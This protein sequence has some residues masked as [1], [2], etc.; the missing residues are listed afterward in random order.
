MT[1]FVYNLYQFV[2]G[3]P[4]LAPQS[5]PIHLSM[6]IPDGMLKNW[7]QIW[8]RVMYYKRKCLTCSLLVCTTEQHCF[9]VE[10]AS[11][12]YMDVKKYIDV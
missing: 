4:L 5:D 7:G 9:F 11:I 2:Q 6:C 3:G 12:V 8:L 10:E 1:A